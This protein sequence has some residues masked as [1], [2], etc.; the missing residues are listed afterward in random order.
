MMQQKGP[1]QIGGS[2]ISSEVYNLSLPGKPHVM[3]V[4][5][6]INQTLWFRS[7]LWYCEEYFMRNVSTTSTGSAR[8][9]LWQPMLSSSIYRLDLRGPCQHRGACTCLLKAKDSALCCPAICITPTFFYAPGFFQIRSCF[10]FITT[11]SNRLPRWDDCQKLLQKAVIDL[12][13]I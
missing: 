3:V 6:I 10:G 4:G 13:P 5:P 1:A 2:F 12:N 7:E 8:P 11:G 9:L